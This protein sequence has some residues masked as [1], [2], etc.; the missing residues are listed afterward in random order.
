MC[1]A[2]GSI[3]SAEETNSKGVQLPPGRAVSLAQS[4]RA[5][6]D[7]QLTLW[8][9]ASL[10]GVGLLDDAVGAPGPPPLHDLSWRAADTGVPAF[11]ESHCCT[12]VCGDPTCLSRV[13]LGTQST[14]QGLLSCWEEPSGTAQPLQ[15]LADWTSVLKRG[16]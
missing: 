11:K 12:V 13:L 15:D 14:V 16:N 10:P 5:E 9:R 4:G 8:G 7:D 1:K 2:P 3:P 6:G